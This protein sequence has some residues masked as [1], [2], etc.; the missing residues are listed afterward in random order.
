MPNTVRT[1]GKEAFYSCERLT[2]IKFSKKTY[3]RL[4]TMHLVIVQG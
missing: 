3:K 1:I 2:E 4:E